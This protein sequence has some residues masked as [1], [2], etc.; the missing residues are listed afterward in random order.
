M[1]ARYAVDPANG[2]RQGDRKSDIRLRWE[3]LVHAGTAY[4]PDI[5]QALCMRIQTD[6]EAEQDKGDCGCQP[7][8][9]CFGWMRHYAAQISGNY[10]IQDRSRSR[11]EES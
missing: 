6:H 5:D 1:H 10:F 3:A 7:R 9:Q 4:P 2:L 11:P 8:E